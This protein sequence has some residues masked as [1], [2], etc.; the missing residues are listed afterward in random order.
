LH[1]Y[2]VKL[3]PGQQVKWVP[4]VEIDKPGMYWLTVTD[5]NG[6]KGVD[7][8]NVIQKDCMTGVHFPTAFTPN[9]DGKE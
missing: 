2:F 4:W 3:S 7:S 6:C 5:A 9:G 8:I 1:Q